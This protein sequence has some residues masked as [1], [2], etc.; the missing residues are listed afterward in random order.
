MCRATRHADPVHQ[1]VYTAAKLTIVLLI[2]G[3]G[4]GTTRKS[5]DIHLMH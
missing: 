5:L 1:S 3:T 4:L 2:V